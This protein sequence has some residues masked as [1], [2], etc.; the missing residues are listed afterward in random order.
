MKFYFLIEI[1]DKKLEKFVFGETVDDRLR[2]SIW[3]YFVV[4]RQAIFSLDMLLS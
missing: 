3:I 2:Y 4:K 1:E